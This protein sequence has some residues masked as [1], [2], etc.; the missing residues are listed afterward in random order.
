MCAPIDTDSLAASFS[1]E[2]QARIDTLLESFEEG[3][4]VDEITPPASPPPPPS[5]PTTPTP[6]VLALRHRIEE[7][8]NQL[9]EL[10][11]IVIDD[12]I[13]SIS[14]VRNLRPNTDLNWSQK[15]FYLL[16]TARIPMFCVLKIVP[17]DD[18]IDP[19]CLDIYVINYQVKMSVMNCL[20]L[21]L[22]NE[23]NNA[24]YIL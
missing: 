17:T 11:Y 23:Y 5:P 6:L 14:G 18:E 13:I 4:L 9:R 7:L 22:R 21:Y 20:E 19:D 16:C 24:V 2:F 8:E 10:E 12:Q 15:M 1:P 3:E